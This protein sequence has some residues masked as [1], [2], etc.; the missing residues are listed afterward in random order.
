M[1]MVNNDGTIYNSDSKSESSLSNGNSFKP[2]DICG[3]A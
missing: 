3:L 1:G 2:V